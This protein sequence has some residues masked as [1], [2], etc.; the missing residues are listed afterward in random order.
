M[1]INEMTLEQ[2]AARR[3][4]IRSAMTAPDA[5]LAA[6]TTEVEAL[7]RRAAELIAERADQAAAE[8]RRATLL[9]LLGNGHVGTPVPTGAIENRTSVVDSAEYRTAWLKNVAVTREGVALFD[10]MTAEERTAFTH[11]TTNS[12][13]VVPTVILNRIVELMDSMCP[14]LDDATASSMTQGFGVPRHKGIPAGDATSTAEGTPNPDDEENAFDLLTLTGVEIKK[15]VNITRKMQW[16][17][18][19]A[20]EDW[21]V[22]ELARRIAVAKEAVI[23][24]RLD[25]TAPTG[26]SIVANAGIDAAN[27]MTSVHYTDADIRAIFAQLHG[28]GRR[29]VYAN[30]ATIWNKLIGIVDSNGDK[31]FVAN[32]MGDPVVQGRIY[33]AEVKVDENLANNVVYFGIPSQLLKNDFDPLY[34][35]PSVNPT[36]F[37]KT[38][39]GYS[40]FDAGLYDPKAYVKAT[41]TP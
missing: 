16:Q 29:V 27:I 36:S 24:A 38:V 37:V 2:I 41:F 28:T 17:S 13:S 6:L 30:T 23:L 3:A 18:I 31:L 40:L 20:F 5:D 7:N 4:E 9:A 8:E 34:V 33:G 22:N 39:A 32:S 12:G 15:H 25:G 21:L 11:T 35:L 14:M 1:N 26:G 10:P 19:S